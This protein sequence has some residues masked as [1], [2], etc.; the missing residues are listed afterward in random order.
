MVFFIQIELMLKLTYL[1]FLVSHGKE[2]VE[3]LEEVEAEGIIYYT[4]MGHISIVFI[5]VIFAINPLLKVN[6]VVPFTPGHTLYKRFITVRG[7]VHA[8]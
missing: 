5:E 1:H 6:C 2:S 3:P 8:V 4:M 7:C